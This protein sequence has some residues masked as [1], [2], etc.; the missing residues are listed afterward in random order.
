M[1]NVQIKILEINLILGAGGNL[2]MAEAIFQMNALHAYDCQM[3]GSLCEKS[4]WLQ[5]ALEHFSDIIDIKR[6]LS[7]QIKNFY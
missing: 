6:I 1:S 7:L 2:Q 5:R 3:I 4:G